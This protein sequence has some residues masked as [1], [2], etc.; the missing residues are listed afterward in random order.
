MPEFPNFFIQ[1]DYR[2]DGY[3][4]STEENNGVVANTN[5]N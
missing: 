1:G 5:I 3:T 4:Y 2:T